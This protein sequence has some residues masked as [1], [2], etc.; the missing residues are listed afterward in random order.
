MRQR[1]RVYT[2][3]TINNDTRVY[4]MAKMAFLNGS[5]KNE[6]LEEI[7]AMYLAEYPNEENAI[8][9]ARR[10]ANWLDSLR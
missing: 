3:A 2:N 6:N 7:E 9:R 10:D 1:R 4:E 8:R 5:R